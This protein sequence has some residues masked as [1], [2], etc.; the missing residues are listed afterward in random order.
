[1]LLFQVLDAA[2]VLIQALVVDFDDPAQTV[3]G[4]HH[5]GEP[6][7]VIAVQTHHFFEVLS[8][9]LFMIVLQTRHQFE[10]F[11]DRL[12]PFVDVHLFFPL[13]AGCRLHFQYASMGP[14]HPKEFHGRFPGRSR[15]QAAEV[16]TVAALLGSP[17][18][19]MIRDHDELHRF[20]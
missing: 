1:M 17:G 20:Q 15:W 19:R 10:A 18:V 13:A 7:F 4:V 8:V 12:D 9:P 5:L 2:F 6:L 14:R 16:P 11:G 3:H